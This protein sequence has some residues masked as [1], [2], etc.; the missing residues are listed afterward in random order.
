MLHH[1][2]VESARRHWV[3]VASAAVLVVLIVVMP[4]VWQRTAEISSRTGRS[5]HISIAAR[6]LWLSGLGGLIYL[7]AMLPMRGGWRVREP[8]EAERAA[9]R[10]MLRAMG[11]AVIWL[12]IY[13]T[14]R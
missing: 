3:L 14:S 9:A 12:A 10:L 11:I 13:L 1:G 4:G 6:G 7:A 2:V 5:S 8:T